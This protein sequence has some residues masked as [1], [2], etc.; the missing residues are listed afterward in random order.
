MPPHQVA[1]SPTGLLATTGSVLIRRCEP[2]VV[3]A[4]Q[5]QGGIT[6]KDFALAAEIDGTV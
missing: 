5:S 1:S 3:E 2:D 6:Q 4:R